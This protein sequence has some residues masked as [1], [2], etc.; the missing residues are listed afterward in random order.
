MRLK[1]GLF[2]QKKGVC[3]DS[4]VSLFWKGEQGT[5]R[6]GKCQ[7]LLKMATCHFTEIIKETETSLQSS[8]LNQ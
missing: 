4:S 6:K 1:I 7:L 5:F 2:I 8:A 3:Q